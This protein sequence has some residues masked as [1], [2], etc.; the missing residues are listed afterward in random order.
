MRTYDFDGSSLKKEE[1]FFSF[2]LLQ[3]RMRELAHQINS[4]YAGKEMVAVCILK[5]ASIFFADM[6]R[7]LTP[8]LSCEFIGFSSSPNSL[9]KELKMTLLPSQ[10]ATKNHYLIFDDRALTGKTL[11]SSIESLKLG[12]P[13][14][15]KTCVL[16]VNNQITHIKIDYPGFFIDTQEPLVGYGMD[17]LEVGRQRKDVGSKKI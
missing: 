15:I 17:D 8:S 9:E 4:D 2:S 10:Q 7:L 11:I 14:S 16:F 13:Q 3:K 5:G 1:L 12:H 6:I